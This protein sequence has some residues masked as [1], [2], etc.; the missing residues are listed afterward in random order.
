[1]IGALGAATVNAMIA[2]N[3]MKRL[4]SAEEM[5]QVVAWLCT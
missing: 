3:L 2:D 1:M 4:G 5:A